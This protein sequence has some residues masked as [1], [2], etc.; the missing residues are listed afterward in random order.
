MKP[1]TTQRLYEAQ[2][3]WIRRVL[4]KLDLTFAEFIEELERQVK[5]KKQ[6]AWFLSLPDVPKMINVAKK[7]KS[8]PCRVCI[9]QG[10]AS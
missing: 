9:R 4:E 10:M 5:M 1:Q 7:I 6:N 3:P 8:K 2:M